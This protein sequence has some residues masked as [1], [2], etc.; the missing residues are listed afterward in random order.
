M[1]PTD[2]PVYAVGPW[3]LPV[4]CD[5]PWTRVL[6]HSPPKFISYCI[7]SKVVESRAHGISS[8][9]RVFSKAHAQGPP[10]PSSEAEGFEGRTHQTAQQALQEIRLFHHC[11]RIMDAQC[12]SEKKRRGFNNRWKVARE[13]KDGRR[14]STRSRQSV[15]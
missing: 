1:C 7:V 8:S 13:S 15:I 10:A 6:T 3:P 12:D 4:P 14:G 5:T 2:V 9:W 11:L